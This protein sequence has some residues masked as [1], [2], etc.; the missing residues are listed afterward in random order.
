MN[1]KKLFRIQDII[2]IIIFVMSL[3]STVYVSFALF[4][5]PLGMGQTFLS[6][7]LFILV[8]ST[9]FFAVSLL[10]HF[11]GFV[12]KSWIF[13]IF[14]FLIAIIV[15]F[16]LVSVFSTKVIT[17]SE[18]RM[19]ATVKSELIPIITY[20]E[21]YQ[22]QYGKVPQ[23]IDTS[24]IKPKT[25]NNIY[26][27]STSDN[28]I[29]GLYVPSLDIDG[30]QIF[31]DSRDKHWYQFHNDMYQYYKDKKDRPESIE[32]YISFHN[33]KDVTSSTMKKKN[34]VWTDTKKE[35]IKNSQNHLERHKK[36]VK[37]VMMHHVLLWG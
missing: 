32:R 13:Y 22:E 9:L 24:S 1:G 35:A 28:F 8:F 3:L 31:Y 30:A 33:Q 19:V 21:K 14:Q 11:T 23:S 18:A 12:K 5:E 34:G 17:D 25:I 10:R 7:Q 16:F 36:A 6:L 20:L 2:S 15:S 37:K 4:H 26:Y 27:Y 29:I